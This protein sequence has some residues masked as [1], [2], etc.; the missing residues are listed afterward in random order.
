MEPKHNPKFTKQMNGRINS[1]FLRFLRVFLL[2]LVFC[3]CTTTNHDDP[4]YQTN[5]RVEEA[6]RTFRNVELSGFIT[7]AQR[8]AVQ[9]ARAEYE[10][11]HVKAQTTPDD[12]SIEAAKTAA[13]KLIT[14]VGNLQ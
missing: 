4:L 7:A 3:G 14:L 10:S 8:E 9:A 11:A 13:D 2:S 5:L 6:M 1:S 12:G